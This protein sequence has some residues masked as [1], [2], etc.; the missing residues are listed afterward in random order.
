MSLPVIIG[1][2]HRLSSS[3]ATNYSNDAVELSNPSDVFR[4]CAFPEKKSFCVKRLC[5]I[6]LR[7]E[8]CMKCPSYTWDE[9]AWYISPARTQLGKSPEGVN[10]YSQSNFFSLIF[11]TPFY[12]DEETQWPSGSVSRSRTTYPGLYPWAGQGLSTQPFIPL[13]GR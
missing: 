7:E 13:V 8:N 4:I 5:R 1:A 3:T 9:L 11:G 12:F 10:I 6:V 2:V